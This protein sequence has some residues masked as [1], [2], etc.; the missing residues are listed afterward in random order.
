ML[1]SEN[2]H[3]SDVCVRPKWLLTTLTALFMLLWG[4]TDSHAICSKL[5][6][7]MPAGVSSR[8]AQVLLLYHIKHAFYLASN[9]HIQIDINSIRCTL[10]HSQL[11][12]S[13]VCVLYACSELKCVGR[14]SAS[15]SSLAA[16]V[17]IS[18]RCL[19]CLSG[20]CIVQMW[21][22]HKHTSLVL[23]LVLDILDINHFA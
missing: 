4:A 8:Y 3:L 21:N 12:A 16:L 18:G 14:S 19:P 6:L 7:I 17:Y 15:G 23:F 9:K 5:C 13:R 10:T 22:F 1:T 20:M 2:V 11:Y